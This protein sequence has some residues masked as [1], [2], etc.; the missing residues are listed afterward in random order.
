MSIRILNH[1]V[2]L[3]CFVLMLL[4]ALFAA[5]ALYLVTSQGG[6]PVPGWRS[7]LLFAGLVVLSASAMGLYNLRLRTHFF[8]LALRFILMAALVL[9]AV[10]AVH[11]A[12]P[13][14]RLSAVSYVYAIS[15]VVLAALLTRYLL[16]RFF[17]EGF[18]RS[19]VLV[20]GAGQRA[21]SIT[22]L[23]RR[24]DRLGFTIVGFLPA[25][26]EKIAI[27][28]EKLVDCAGDLFGYCKR[29]KIDEIVVAMDDRR[30]AFP[31]R[32]LLH[33]RINGI[34]VIDI[35]EFLER[36][37]ATLRLDLLKPS[38]MIFSPGFERSWARDLSG[39]L[40]DVVASLLLLA[41]AW[42]L[43]LLAAIAIKLEDGI[44]APVLY[45]QCRVGKDNRMFTVLKFRSMQVDAES[46][47]V[48]RWASLEDGRVTR[49][50]AWL[51]PSR[52][53]ELP[54]LWNILRGD[55]R[56]VGPRPERPEFVSGFAENLP[57]Y[58]ERHSVPPGLTGWAQLRYAYGSS[59]KDAIEK[60]KYDLYY[61]KHHNLMFDLVI[62]IQTVE[63]ILFGKG[64]R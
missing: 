20:Y 27:P 18:L 35:V 40:F 39:R 16:G 32:D 21:D 1:H 53:D 48:A 3:P 58:S 19:R 12:F 51:R 23:R 59:E 13:P 28:V 34:D 2:P 25:E 61:V 36:E 64:A 49:V 38:W 47:G 24:T 31:I 29:Q 30:L 4:E 62:L 63:V 8:G 17:N 15:L 54:Q 50:G 52:I 42:P 60:L 11:L 22:K 14:S 26:G 56:F 10:V 57:Y 43:M 45:R 9:A 44:R 41:V 7:S 5:A 6:T 33:C 37:T 55:M 46:D